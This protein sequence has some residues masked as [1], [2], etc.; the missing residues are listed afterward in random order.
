MTSTSKLGGPTTGITARTRRRAW[1]PGAASVLLVAGSCVTS[2]ALLPSTSQAAQRASVG[3]SSTR[4]GRGRVAHS[5]VSTYCAKLPA[6]KI[7]PIVGGTVKLFEAVVKKGSLECIYFDTSP[8][9]KVRE[10]VLTMQPHMK[11][12]IFT[13]SQGEALLKAGSPKTVKILF[14]T[15]SSVGIAAFSWTYAKPVNGG[16]LVGLAN[17]KGSTGYGAVIGGAAKT[18][19][20]AASYVSALKKLLALAIAA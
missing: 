20:S 6:S 18:F 11:P 4:V 1:M 3:A 15:Q 14:T 13:R 17:Y 8:G 2:L 16:Q 5:T 12:A 9:V 19:G 10:V 7:S